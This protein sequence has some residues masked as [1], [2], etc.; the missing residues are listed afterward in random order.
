MNS[1]KIIIASGVCL[2]LEIAS[3]TLLFLGLVVPT[4][5]AATGVLFAI[6]AT[7]VAV[8]IAFLLATLPEKK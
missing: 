8:G 4:L 3:I 5:R 6:F 2:G 1:K 7:S